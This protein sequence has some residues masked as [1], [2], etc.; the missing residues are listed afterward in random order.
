MR[1]KNRLWV[2]FGVA[3]LISGCTVDVHRADESGVGGLP[4]PGT[5]TGTGAYPGTGAAPDVG[6]GD[7]GGATSGTGASGGTDPGPGCVTT[8]GS[9]A[10]GGYTSGGTSTAGSTGEGGYASGGA[11]GTAGGTGTA[12]STGEGG[13]ASGGGAAYRNGGY[14]GGTAIVGPDGQELVADHSLYGCDTFVATS[15]DTGDACEVASL[16]TPLCATDS[17][18]PAFENASPVCVASLGGR[19]ACALACSSNADCPSDMV[20]ANDYRLGAT[21]MFP[22]VRWEPECPGYC[23]A[24]EQECGAGVPCCDGLVCA[25]WGECEA[26]ECLPFSFGCGEGLPGCCDGLTCRDGVCQSN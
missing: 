8:G 7:A 3:S 23:A 19:P 5:E 10:E 13:Y 25:P 20:C 2:L 15:Y 1:M 17:D 26:H 14:A 16:C 18:C 6:G 9:T 11:T 12:G 21:C 22:N 4:D 24:T